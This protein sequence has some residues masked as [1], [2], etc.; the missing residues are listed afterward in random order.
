MVKNAPKKDTQLKV[1]VS[2]ELE[3][4]F[5]KA[6]LMYVGN[7]SALAHMLIQSFCESVDQHGNTLVWPPKYAYWKDK[8]VAE[9][10]EFP[11][12]AAE[13][14]TAYPR[15]NTRRTKS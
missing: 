13:E 15:K 12:L 10:K 7:P 8:E 5:R 1:R 6:S 14:R 11:R 4:R 3:E 9:S 2:S